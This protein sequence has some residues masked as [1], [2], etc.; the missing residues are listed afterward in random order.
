M[1]SVVSSPRPTI[2]P[3][4]RRCS[5]LELSEKLRELADMPVKPE[6]KDIESVSEF[7]D[8]IHQLCQEAPAVAQAIAAAIRENIPDPSPRLPSKRKRRQDPSYRPSHAVQLVPR[9][10]QRT[11]D[12]NAVDGPMT[13]E[14]PIPESESPETENALDSMICVDTAELRSASKHESKPDV[15]S[16]TLAM[17]EDNAAKSDTIHCNTMSMDPTGQRAESP[18]V[19]EQDP[20]ESM[21]FLDTVHQMVNIVH[22]L[23]RYQTDLPRTVHRRILQSLHTTQE[24]I[25]DSTAHQWSDG[26]MWMEVLERGSATNR[27]CSVL[28][29]LEYIGAS[30]WYDEQ[31]EHAKRT[32]CTM[33]NKPVGEKGAATH[34]LDRIT[35]EHSLLSRKTIT[36]QCSRGKRLRELV[37]K[38]GLG[39]LISS[40]IWDYTKRTGPQFNQLVRDFKADT[41]RLALFRILTPQVEQLVHKGCTDPEALYGALRENDIVSEDELQEMK[42]KHQSESGSTSA[43]TLSKAVDRLTGQVSTQL[44]NKRKLDVNDTIT[45]N[46]SVE[47][48]IDLFARLRA[49]EWLDSWAIM[50]AMR[51]SDRP[52]F[53]RFGESI[54]LDSIGRHGQMRS[55]KR[56]FQV[57]AGKIA[58]FRRDNS[59][60]LI[61]YC[62]V[63]HDNSHFTLLE[64]N[65]SEKAIR[66]Y[67]SQA[68]LTAINGTKKTRIAALVEDEFG[69]LGY[70]YTE[71]PTP[72]QRD[73]W[74]CGTRVVWSFR[75][76][77]NGLDIGS[78]DTVLSSERLNMDI[79]SGLQASVEWNAMQKYNRSRKREPKT[80][81][82]TPAR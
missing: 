37:E 69:D 79:V 6:T 39:I 48:S 56:P 76:L 72:Q 42:A 11:D 13:P 29:M 60:P 82:Q 21:S 15:H 66:H 27:R 80:N 7:R 46:G 28:N 51:I 4:Q 20:T 63:N 43:V 26:R 25:R 16:T 77:A 65:D 49:G 41:Q 17:D 55:I 3:S 18:P 35:R 67:D 73:G 47:L 9:K 33:E 64:V 54:P 12:K 10:K 45:I 58:M 44:F 36:N 34:V 78:W 68:P 53:V 75:R 19:P 5:L 70:K 71:A 59:R 1:D 8:L 52:D 74:S 30:K 62:P 31:I 22:L 50:A 2:P 32:V 38:I 40:K 24:P 23:N 61:F 81:A 57:W 14:S